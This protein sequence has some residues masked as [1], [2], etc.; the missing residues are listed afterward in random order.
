MP[1][2]NW[3]YDNHPTHH[4]HT[5]PVPAPSLPTT[6]VKLEMHTELCPPWQNTIQLCG[7][8]LTPSAST[9]LTMT[10][11]NIMMPI[12]QPTMTKTTKTISTS[13]YTPLHDRCPISNDTHVHHC[14]QSVQLCKSYINTVRFSYRTT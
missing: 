11:H 3:Q 5:A 12:T 9:H 13:L 7:I 14:H 10:F 8:Q 4:R 6:V 1:K 2:A